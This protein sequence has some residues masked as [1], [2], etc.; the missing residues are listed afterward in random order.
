MAD[1]EQ[2][3]TTEVPA[4]DGGTTTATT[5]TG[6]TPVNPSIPAV[7]PPATTPPADNREPETDPVWLA[8]RLARE[9]KSAVNDFLTDNNF[10]KPDD[11]K[12]LLEQRKTLAT[13]QQQAEQ[14]APYQAFFKSSLEEALASVPESHKEHVNS[15]LAK[16][17][18][19]MEQFQAL[20]DLM[21]LT[22]QPSQPDKKPTPKGIDADAG[23][24]NNKGKI[25]TEK[26]E[27]AARNQGR[28]AR[29]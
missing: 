10:E 4:G 23:K 7:K 15:V 18:G 1:Q 28:Q 25:S 14:L 5:Q 9:R 22:G 11:F 21:K 24:D 6:A 3:L 17:P 20:R 29:L 2:T 16:I 12:A 8:K 19:E 26:Q 13:L 27:A